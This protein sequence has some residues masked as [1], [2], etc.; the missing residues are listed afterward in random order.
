MDITVVE[1][2]SRNANS[3]VTTFCSRAL[4]DV[5]CLCLYRNSHVNMLCYICDFLLC[6]SAMR[7]SHI[8]FFVNFCHTTL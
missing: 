7:Y 3:V 2:C 8:G 5:L 4:L 1:F 6:I